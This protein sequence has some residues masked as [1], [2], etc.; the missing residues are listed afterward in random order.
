[1]TTTTVLSELAGDYVIDPARSRTG[2][3]ARHTM[4]TRVRGHFES[5]EGGAHLD[6]DDPSRSSAELSVRAASIQTHNPQRDEPLRTKFLDAVNHPY[7]TF[8]ST[9]VTQV[10]GTRFKVTG[11]LTVRG[12]T[13]T[14]T[15]DFELTGAEQDPVDGLRAGF[16]GSVTIDRKDWGVNWNAATGVMVAAKVTLEFDVAA[17]RRS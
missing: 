7:I 3:V 4:G 11:D 17:V 12:V 14:V 13:K 8:L 15:V 9:R 1:M 6:G 5:F 2:F 10:D 16:R